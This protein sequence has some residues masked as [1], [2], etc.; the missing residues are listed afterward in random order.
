[1]SSGMFSLLCLCYVCTSKYSVFGNYYFKH[2]FSYICHMLL[3]SW[4]SSDVTCWKFAPPILPCIPRLDWV[5]LCWHVDIQR[6]RASRSQQTFLAWITATNMK[7]VHG[8]ETTNMP[9]KKGH[10]SL[11]CSST[12][13]LLCLFS[14]WTIYRTHSVACP[15]D[16]YRHACSCNL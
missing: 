12:H 4:L 8:N 16:R 6:G 13:S 11:L 9:W 5:V 7:Q 10:I 14:T 3:N 1:M 2:I 15:G